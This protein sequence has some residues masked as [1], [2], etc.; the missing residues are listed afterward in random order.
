MTMERPFF[1]EWKLAL[2]EQGGR[3]ITANFGMNPKLGKYYRTVCREC[4]RKEDPARSRCVTCG[5]GVVK[6]VYERTKELSGIPGSE[7]K[8]SRP[9]Y[10]YQVPLDMIPGIG[11]ASLRK[12][13]EVIGTDMDVLHHTSYE[14]LLEAV[15]AA[16][17]NK[18]MAVRNGEA[19]IAEGG[20]GTYG[21]L[22]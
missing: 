13:R 2:E 19:D 20:G 14:Q 17:A 1:Q 18:I 11:P 16:A 4:G 10:I 12:L 22:R 15:N 8:R 9:P 3:A 21:R 5:G 6:G 7:Q